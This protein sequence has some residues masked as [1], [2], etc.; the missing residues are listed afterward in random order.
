MIVI[1][2]CLPDCDCRA[3]KSPQRKAT[4]GAK[5]DP[6]GPEFSSESH[7]LRERFLP[8]L[9]LLVNRRLATGIG[10][11]FGNPLARGT[12]REGNAGQRLGLRYPALPSTKAASS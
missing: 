5:G 8:A 4:F 6:R 2:S 3:G 9:A 10:R 1:R 12:G 11:E 7:R